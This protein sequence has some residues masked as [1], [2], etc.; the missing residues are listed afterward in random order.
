M[1]PNGASFKLL[2]ALFGGTMARPKFPAHY[3]WCF[4]TAKTSDML[5][6]VGFTETQ[7]I[8]FY[9]HIYYDKIP[10]AKQ[11][12]AVCARDRA[13]RRAVVGGVRLHG[14]PEGGV[15]EIPLAPRVAPAA[16]DACRPREYAV[17][18]A[19]RSGAAG[20]SGCG[21]LHATGVD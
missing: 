7:V 13:G 1:L 16:G 11:L 10:L 14:C 20:A 21:A 5:R 6:T 18:G 17:N 4:A 19:R 12:H 2:T 3:S 15:D 8:P 9:G